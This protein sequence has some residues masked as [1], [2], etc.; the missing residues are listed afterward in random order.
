MRKII[1]FPKYSRLGASSRYRT[2]QYNSAIC[3]AGLR[4]EA[5]P[6]FDDAYLLSKYHK[7]KANIFDVLRGFARRLWAVLTVTQGAVIFV[8][9]ELIPYAPALLERWLK[10]RGCRIVVDYDDALFHQY[11]MHSCPLVRF[12]LGNKIG[13]VMRLANTVIVGNAYLADYARS[14]GAV[15]VLVVPSVVD[16]KR[17]RVLDPKIKARRVFTIGWIGS[18]STARYLKGVAQALAEVCSDGRAR[19]CLI[20]SGPIDLP[21]VPTELIDWKEETESNDIHL[22]DVGIMPLPNEPWER[23]KCGLK[24]IQYMACGLPVVASPVG[25]NAEIVESGYN[26]YLA[27]T[28]DEWI[29]ALK[30]LKANDELCARLGANGRQFA[31]EKYCLAI[32]APTVVDLL[33]ECAA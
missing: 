29:F 31:E 30:K 1:L 16:I 5:S 8:E 12:F 33:K 15:R 19:V 2:Y 14:V 28:I 22:F 13:T 24:L 21:G 9:Y 18:P 3:S 25:V 4:F 6:L 11:D 20:G 27:A 23:G 7:G 32:T 10:W 26:G 17:Y